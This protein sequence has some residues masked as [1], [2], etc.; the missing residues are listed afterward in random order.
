MDEAR[1]Y[2]DRMRS[3]PAQEAIPKLIE[4]LRDES[5]YL[6][7]RAG[8]AIASFGFEAAP[9]VEEVVRSGLWY[10]KA[11]ALRVLGQIAAPQSLSVLME[12]VDDT[13]RTIAEASIDALIGFC[14]RDRALAVAKVLHGRG[15]PFREHVLMMLQRMNPGAEVRLKRLIEASPFMGPE[16]NLSAA[17]DQRL[18]ETVSD[19]Y[20]G[21]RWQHLEAVDTLTEPPE[22]LVRYLRGSASE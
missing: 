2:I 17:D 14:K 5:W 21:I 6:R 1:H 22:N 3:H 4:L 18:A 19:E 12:F 15:G 16:G 11:A 20:W 8:E 9:A 7:E 13:N 10:T